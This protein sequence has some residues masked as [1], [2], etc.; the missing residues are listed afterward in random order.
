MKKIILSLFTALLL[1]ITGCD[2]NEGPFEIRVEQGKKVLYSGKKPAKG[3]IQ[4]SIYNKWKDA[5]VVVYEI[6]FNKGV[7]AGDFKLYNYNGELVVD[8]KGK[9]SKNGF[10]G[11]IEEPL[12]YGKGKGIYNIDPDFLISFNG[13]NYSEF[14]YKTLID[15]N[16]SG[17]DSQF[18]VV[19][20]KFEDSLYKFTSDG[21]ML[22]LKADFKNGKRHGEYLEYDACTGNLVYEIDYI[23]GKCDGK[24][25]F[26]D[27]RDGK[28]IED[29]E[30]KNGKRHGKYLKYIYDSLSEEGQYKDGKRQGIWKYYDLGKLSY[31]EEYKDDKLIRDKLIRTE[32]K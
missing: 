28:L 31:I 6:Y 4:N 14:S 9:W 24:Y 32:S 12:S 23:E 7:P 3:W 20:N 18:R 25:K 26:Y 19:N 22:L 21:S 2:N 17:S 15:G 5:N 11:T 1:F 27:F 8:G 29:I 10:E 13:E 16:Y 30:Y